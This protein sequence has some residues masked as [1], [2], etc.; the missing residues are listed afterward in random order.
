MGGRRRVSVLS[1]AHGA[2]RALFGV[3]QSGFGLLALGGKNIKAGT[4]A[5]FASTGRG[6]GSGGR[7]KGHPFYGNQHVKVAAYSRG[8]KKASKK[9]RRLSQWKGK[10]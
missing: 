8:K 3:Q 5:A 1:R 6:S 7:Q 2:S 4:K 10:R 9:K